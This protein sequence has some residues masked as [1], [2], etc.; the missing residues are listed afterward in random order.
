MLGEEHVQASPRPGTFPLLGLEEK[1][2]V[3]LDDWDFS[4]KVVPFSTQ[5]LW[6]EGK[7][8]PIT[9]PQNKDYS[10][11]CL[12]R[13][14]APV[15]ITCKEKYLGPI[16]SAAEEATESGEASVNT[17]LARR[18]KVF[19]FTKKLP[20]QVGVTIPACSVCFSRMCQEYAAQAS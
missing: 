5:L 18:L 14:S 1:R 13:G 15:F 17:M 6:Y 20:M 16:L 9:R 11:H 2:I 8:F 3:L 19:H 10:G 12:Y 4:G 7:M